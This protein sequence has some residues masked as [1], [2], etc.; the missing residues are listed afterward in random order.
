M[1]EKLIRT[2]D[3]RT[4]AVLRLALG[5]V[6]F[7]HGAQK[8]LGWFG[9]PGFQAT[10]DF[11]GR[12]LGIPWPL[13]VLAVVA[14]FAGGLALLVGFLGRVAA[15]LIAVEMLVAVALV[16]LPY[17]FFM[18]W[19]G[20]KQGEGFEFHVLAIA[21]LVTVAVRGS[22]AWSVDRILSRTFHAGGEVMHPRPA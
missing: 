22:G 15:A 8:A 9:G 1:W 12:N 5:V 14:E 16:H 10:V 18:N 6:F 4:L 7:L 3:D 13:A 20:S 11:F 19:T 17:G 2:E 21:M